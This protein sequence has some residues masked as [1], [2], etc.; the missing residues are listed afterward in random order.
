MLNKYWQLLI[1]FFAPYVLA[2][3]YYDIHA[4]GWHWY[5]EAKEHKKIVPQD[6]VKQMDALK[7]TIQ[8]AMD[9]AILNPTDD[10]V[11]N[12]IALQNQLSNQS[13]IFANV[14]QKVLLE[15]PELNYSLVHPTNNLAKQVDTDLHHQEEDKAIARLAKESGLFFF[16]KST[17]PYC[18]KFAPIVKDFAQTYGLTVIP[19]TLDGIS[20][21]DFPDS[22]IDN[23][24]AAK[25]HVTL[26]PSLFAVNPYTH[27][28]YPISYGLISQED[29]RQRV[30]DIARNFQGGT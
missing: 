2:D 30:L 21:P 25:F 6:P 12:Y 13:S 4:Q 20:L 28:A 8:R 1:I 19:I 11:K 14:W 15:N 26:E 7:A 17:C 5:N 22:K 18:Q 24:Q 29:L 10:N 27:I 3:D 23:G 9:N 16:Y